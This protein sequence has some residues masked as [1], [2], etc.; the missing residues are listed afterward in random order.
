MTASHCGRR[1]HP[2]RPNAPGGSDLA[3]PGHQRRVSHHLNRGPLAHEDQSLARAELLAELLPGPRGGA[4]A[5]CSNG[6][7][8]LAL[9]G[10][11]VAATESMYEAADVGAG[12]IE[13]VVM[14][15]CEAM[16]QLMLFDLYGHADARAEEAFRIT[17]EMFDDV[18]SPVLQVQ[19]GFG[20]QFFGDESRVHDVL[21][22]FA[23]DPTGSCGRWPATTCSASSATRSLDRGR[24]RTPGP[25][26]ARC[27]PM[28]DCST[29]AAGTVPGSPST[30]CSVVSRRSTATAEAVARPRC[31]CASRPMPSPPLLVHCLDHLADALDRTGGGGAGVL[32]READALAAAADVVRPGRAPPST[33][34][35]RA[36]RGGP[37]CGTTG[38][39]GCSP[40]R[41]ATPVCPTA[42]DS[43]SSPGC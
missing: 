4:S 28:P 24:R 13:P 5:P 2:P 36:R 30:T 40:R 26:T 16:H 14:L 18:P 15:G 19:K 29:W 22:R 3:L 43:G 8:F 37:P 12:H 42:T 6:R 17:A 27:S 39:S 25:S 7:R 31:G 32:R 21:L 23:L 35:V 11:R 20:A 41:W 1:G 34:L 33:R 10:N 9:T 38:R